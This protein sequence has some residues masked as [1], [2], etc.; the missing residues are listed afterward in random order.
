MPR[1]ALVVSAPSETCSAMVLLTVEIEQLAAMS[2]LIVPLLLVM[3]AIDRPGGAS[4]VTIRLPAVLSA[5]L[6]VAT[7]VF[8]A[9]LPC[10]RALPWG[11]IEG[12]VFGVGL[13]VGVGVGV[14]AA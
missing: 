4:A 2:A 11:V 7:V 12:A 9:A 10:R 3:L 5:S 14:G 1:L 8:A 6:T 13:G